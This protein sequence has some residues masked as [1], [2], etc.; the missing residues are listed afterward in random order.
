MGRRFIPTRNNLYVNTL[1]AG[2][3]FYPRPF[4][5]PMI[6]LRVGEGNTTKL[7]LGLRMIV[8]LVTK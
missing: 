4:L 8:H 2:K 5:Y 3:L 6:G 7:E 1:R